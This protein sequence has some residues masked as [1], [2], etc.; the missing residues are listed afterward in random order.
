MKNLKHAVS[1]K[2]TPQE[3]TNLRY[4]AAVGKTTKAALIRE[5]LI[6]SLDLN[7][8]KLTSTSAN[9]FD[10]GARHVVQLND[11]RNGHAVHQAV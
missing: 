8:Q 7:S 3:E 2:L 6:T 5:A 11:E 9:F 10:E 1:T 4:L